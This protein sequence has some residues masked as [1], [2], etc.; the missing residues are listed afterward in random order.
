VN[1]LTES[2][3]SKLSVWAAQ[4]SASPTKHSWTPSKSKVVSPENKVKSKRT[5]S[6]KKEADDRLGRSSAEKND[7]DDDSA[8]LDDYSVIEQRIFHNASPYNFRQD[9]APL[10]RT[11]FTYRR[12]KYSYGEEK[13]GSDDDVRLWICSNGVPSEHL[14]LDEIKLVYTWASYARVTHGDMTQLVTE[15]TDNEVDEVLEKLSIVRGTDGDFS[16]DERVLGSRDDVAQIFCAE[17][18]DFIHRSVFQKLSHEEQ[19][20]LRLWAARCN[21]R[22]LRTYGDAL[23]RK[24]HH[25]PSWWPNIN[26]VLLWIL[27]VGLALVTKENS[28]V[29]VTVPAMPPLQLKEFSSQLNAQLNNI[30]RLLP[31]KF[32]MIPDMMKTEE[33]PSASSSVDDAVAGSDGVDSKPVHSMESKLDN[34]GNVGGDNDEDDDDEEDDDDDEDE[35]EDDEDD[36]TS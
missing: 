14:S 23:K 8:D 7:L 13:I 6:R 12:N 10:V 28:P 19:A 36:E 3:Q 29:T 9:I 30:A 11:A 31:E 25:K 24:N 1:N 33:K 2:E 5:P 26:A 27:V 21:S 35:E 15:Y 22:H 32:T 18:S 17:G 16:L 20:N 4:G 34:T